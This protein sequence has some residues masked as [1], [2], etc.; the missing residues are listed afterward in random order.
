MKIVFVAAEVAP[1][2]KVGGLAD[3]AGA[4]PTELART[5]IRTQVIS[6]LY[7]QIDRDKYKIE[8]TGLTG[9]IRL[10]YTSHPYE[11][12]KCVDTQDPFRECLF[13]EN[14]YF[15][16][17]EGI[18]T[19]PD[20]EGYVD[21]NA[22]FIFLQK[23]II[24]LII[25]GTLNPDLCHVNDHHTALIP[26]L[27]ANRSINIPSL[28]TVHNFEYQG[29]F[30]QEELIFLEPE[31]RA[32]LSNE[33]PADTDSFNALELGIKFADWT[34]T[35][36][37]T[38]ARELLT[39][40]DKSFG[41][42][43]ILVKHQNCFSGI[44]NG[45]DYSYWNP[46]EDQFIA[47][48]FD[49]DQIV[50][51]EKNKQ[52]L[53]AK[54]EL[55]YN[56]GNPVIGSISRLVTGKGFDLILEIMG[57]ILSLPV[58]LVFLGTGNPVYE[59]RLAE[60]SRKYPT[61]IAFNAT[62]DESLAHAIEAGSDLFLMPSRFEPCGLNQIYSLKYGTLP[63]VHRTGGLADT[64]ID[65]VHKNGNGF[66]FNKYDG[67]TLLTTI[68][69]A[70]EVYQNDR[71][72]WNVLVTNAMQADFSWDRSTEKYRELYQTILKDRGNV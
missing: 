54:C 52:A 20:G 57:R 29:Q 42:Q 51:K 11:L 18:Y 62:Y 22:R 53:L 19:Q 44:L 61:K 14:Q 56:A 47:T 4:L 30:T 17:R 58:Q 13:I 36:S 39:E 26:F 15:F 43:P 37:P 50:L 7:R 69:R 41:L 21:N 68:H 16:G 2:S 12:F 70:V 38:Y 46:A 40:T 31:D 24:D 48:R 23:A 72:R 65:S 9:S 71:E 45:A 59:D 33:Y 60:W 8:A 27:L 10:N 34:N 49:I 25:R 28:L 64:I 63:I 35:V 32:S 55:P 6:P 3:V 66:S 5:G 1:F 67:E